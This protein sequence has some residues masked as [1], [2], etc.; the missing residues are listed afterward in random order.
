METDKKRI[1]IVDDRRSDTQLVKLYLEGT[2]NYLVREVND[3][4]AALSA[5]EEF[6]PQLILLDVKMPGID[7]GELAARFKANPMLKGVPIV[8]LTALVTKREV[9]DGDG[10]VGGVPFLSKPIILPEL[11]ASLRH[12]LGG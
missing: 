3:P 6:Q 1:L 8:F 7:G 12:H 2:N 4:G 10:L 11:A 5:A 9:D